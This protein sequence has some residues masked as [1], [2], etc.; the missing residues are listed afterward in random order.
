MRQ[1]GLCQ[2]CVKANRQA[3]FHQN[4][5]AAGFLCFGAIQTAGHQ[6][7][8]KNKEHATAIPFFC[9]KIIVSK[10]GQTVAVTC[11]IFSIQYPNSIGSIVANAFVVCSA[12]FTGG[13][14]EASC[15]Q[16]PAATVTN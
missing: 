15:D 16:P 6:V 4:L 8:A 3:S 12:F 2:I 1:V 5:A 10:S 14:A 7:T 11:F 9:Q 13:L